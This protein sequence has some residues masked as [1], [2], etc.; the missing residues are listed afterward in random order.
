MTFATSSAL[1]LG[2]LMATAYGA[3]FHFILGG[4]AKRIILY[5]LSAW[6]GFTIG[7]FFG[8]IFNIE[9]F[10]LGAVHLL[11]A[12]LGAWLALLTAWW[13]GSKQ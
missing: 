6:I 4:P 2:F 13:L 3:G 9:L 11:T 8:D 5:I 1:V 10:K 12:S 7:H